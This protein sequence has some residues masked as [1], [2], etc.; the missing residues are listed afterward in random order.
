MCKCVKNTC[1]ITSIYCIRG[2]DVRMYVRPTLRFYST[3]TWVIGCFHCPTYFKTVLLFSWVNSVRCRVGW[4][5]SLYVMFAWVQCN[6][7]YSNR[8]LYLVCER[9]HIYVLF[10]GL[11]CTLDYWWGWMLRYL[12]NKSSQVSFT[13]VPPPPKKFEGTRSIHVG[14]EREIFCRSRIKR[15]YV[16]LFGKRPLLLKWRAARFFGKHATLGSMFTDGINGK[17]ADL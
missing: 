13:V 6:G 11:L 14:F 8:V 4:F 3:S 5:A 2:C 15:I 7:D 17:G 10:Y 9:L 16:G 1:A 12:L